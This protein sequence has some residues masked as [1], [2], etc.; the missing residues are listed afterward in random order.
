MC[1]AEEQEANC[2]GSK[3]IGEE[4]INM[5]TPAVKATGEITSCMHS[6]VGFMWPWIDTLYFMDG[7]L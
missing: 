4:T 6:D 3:L 2:D 5:R 7:V 1:F